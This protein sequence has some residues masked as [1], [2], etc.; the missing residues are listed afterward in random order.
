[1]RW[2]DMVVYE[3]HFCHR[4]KSKKTD[5]CTLGNFKLTA[6]VRGWKN[7]FRKKIIYFWSFH[8]GKLNE[9]VSSLYRGDL[10]EHMSEE[11]SK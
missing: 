10:T 9:H 3:M 11:D 4:T 6:I 1:M 2:M 5:L 8:C 7:I